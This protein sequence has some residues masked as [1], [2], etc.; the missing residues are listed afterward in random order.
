VTPVS[1]PLLPSLVPWF[2]PP[3]FYFSFGGGEFLSSLTRFAPSLFIVNLYSF[4]IFPCTRHI[5]DHVWRRVFSCEFTSGNPTAEAL[6]SD[7]NFGLLGMTFPL[8]PFFLQSGFFFFPP[9]LF[10]I[11]NLYPRSVDFSLHLTL[12]VVRVWGLSP[13]GRDG[14]LSLSRW[15]SCPVFD[16]PSAPRNRMT[17]PTD[18]FPRFL[19][20]RTSFRAAGLGCSFPFIQ[21]E[22][23]VRR[24]PTPSPWQR[25]GPPLKQFRFM[26]GDSSLPWP[27]P[28]P[29]FP[30]GSC[31]VKIT[32]FVLPQQLLPPPN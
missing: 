23:I 1:L 11:P 5:G 10:L 13:L 8:F 27:P 12:L 25:F 7:R 15:S 17:L 19:P 31:S 30:P 26:L 20:R 18:P 16:P 2:A 22:H 14:I 24:I 9:V 29:D 3:Y 6:S 21:P 32:S 28:S 4:V